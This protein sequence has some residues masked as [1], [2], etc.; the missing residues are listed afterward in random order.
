MKKYFALLIYVLLFAEDFFN[1]GATRE[2][3]ERYYLLNIPLRDYALFLCLCFFFL[4]FNKIKQIIHPFYFITFFC[5]ILLFLVIGINNYGFNNL[6]FADIRILLSLLSGI[7]FSF[8]VI[9][10]C[11]INIKRLSHFTIISSLLCFT[12]S[13]ILSPDFIEQKLNG[14]VERVSHPNLYAFGFVI[15]VFFYLLISLRRKL[16]DYSIIAI[17]LTIIFY[18]DIY[19]SKT[20]STLIVWLF[21]L[22]F[23]L[24]SPRIIII[25][26]KINL[27]SPIISIKRILPLFLIIF[28]FIGLLISE[29]SNRLFSIFNISEILNDDRGLEFLDLVNQTSGIFQFLFGRGL[30][31][32]INSVIY[33]GEFTQF[34][35]L[36]LLNFFL[37]FGIIIFIIVLSGIF[38]I[39]FKYFRFL[40]SFPINVHFPLESI[41]FKYGSWPI[42]LPMLFPWFIFLF[43]SGGFAEIPFFTFGFYFFMSNYFSRN[44]NHLFYNFI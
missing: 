26:G 39:L 29:N 24:I 27:S 30:A 40:F 4:F 1:I 15:F 44:K 33:R 13:A 34:L 23:L 10:Y 20:R 6:L 37:K 19:L 17:T 11:R 36:G 25:H 22:I 38:Y 2:N 14:D 8:F 41:V 28:S 9:S 18:F 21:G 31:G 43:I 32:G 3:I 7:S 42:F 16:I 5:F 12:V 35:H